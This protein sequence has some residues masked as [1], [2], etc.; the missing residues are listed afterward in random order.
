MKLIR[1]NDLSSKTITFLAILGAFCAYGYQANADQSDNEM[2]SLAPKLIGIAPLVPVKADGS[3]LDPSLRAAIDAF[4]LIAL[5][6][7]GYCSGTH[8]GNGYVLSAGHCFVP[9]PVPGKP[10]K[11]V[12]IVNQPCSTTTV[13]WGY[14]GSPKTGNPKPL[15]TLVSRCTKIIYA[16]LSKARDFAIFRVNSAPRSYIPLAN[17]TQRTPANTKLTI[18]GYP[19]ARP[20]EWSQYCPLVDPSKVPSMTRQLS[21]T[22]RFIYQCDTEPGNSGSSV[23]AISKNKTLLVVGIHDAAAPPT[24]PYNIGTYLFE[25]KRAM[26]ARQIDLDLLLRTPSKP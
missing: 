19:Q 15:V 25:A 8:I 23:L 4:G 6:S 24:S 16:E 1:G 13:N 26:L 7:S 22:G 14:R 5:G 18:F 3:N 20:L 17:E 10:V 9:E 2:H 12:A 21:G 11:D